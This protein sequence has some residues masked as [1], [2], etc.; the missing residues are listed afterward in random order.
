MGSRNIAV[1]DRCKK[2]A[3]T[4]EG[5]KILGL[6]RITVG[7]EITNSSYSYYGGSGSIVYA[8]INPWDGEWCLACCKEMGVDK[9]LKREE[10]KTTDSTPTLEDI[11][12]EIVREELP[13]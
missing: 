3:E 13:R 2:E 5:K 7:R 10:R 11:I 8:A 12:R 6:S 4:D 9:I 1:C